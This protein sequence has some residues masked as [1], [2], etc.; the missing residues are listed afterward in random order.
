MRV[1]N[2]QSV[3]LMYGLR[4]A[5]VMAG[6]V[7]RR[8]DEKFERS[9][10]TGELLHFELTERDLRIIREIYPEVRSVNQRV[11]TFLNFV[12]F[13]Q[14]KMPYELTTM[15]ADTAGLRFSCRAKRANPIFD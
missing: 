9:V 11:Q 4:E 1:P 15:L 8:C 2:G 5:A 3:S 14:L 7:L 13:C 10:T 6:D 12:I